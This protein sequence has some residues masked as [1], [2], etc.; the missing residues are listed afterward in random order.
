LGARRLLRLFWLAAGAA[1]VAGAAVALVAVLAGTFDRTDG[2]ILLT[3]A[4]ALLA[5]ASAVAALSVI[6]AGML[7]MTG[8]GLAVAAP[9]LFGVATAGIWAGGGGDSARS[10]GTAYLLL[11]ASLMLTTNRLL[12]GSR[13]NLSI[14]FS[15]TAG[16]LAVTTALTILMIWTGHQPGAKVLASLWI[17]TVLGYLLTPVARRLANPEETGPVHKV[18]MR[19]GAQVGTASLRQL[20][21]E[22]GSR[23]SRD[24]LLYVVVAGCLHVGGVDAGPGEAVL[25]PRGVEHEPREDPGSLVLVVAKA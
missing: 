11:L 13:Q 24:D 15:C 18:N 25:V 8:A 23:R 4:T 17:L 16:L 20:A 10:L 6:E 7:R 14:F 9:V 12:A 3:L 21:A 2:H 1:L 19:E 5:G 22:R